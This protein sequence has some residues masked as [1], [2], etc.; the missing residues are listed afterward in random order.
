MYL[1]CLCVFMLTQTC[2]DTFCA[3]GKGLTPGYQ[4]DH[5]PLSHL[6]DPLFFLMNF[7]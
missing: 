4:V 3:R 6:T 5:C 2:T 7:S 1:F